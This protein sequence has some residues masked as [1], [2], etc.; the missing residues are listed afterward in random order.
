MVFT[1]PDNDSLYIALLGRDPNYDGRVF[2]GV[3][4]TG[5]FCRL[6][7]PARKPKQEN[8]TF[9]ESLAEPSRLQQ[10]A[11]G[12]SLEQPSHSTEPKLN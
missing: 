1:L 6:T 4:S 5:V 11:G 3:R 10:V 8:C 9:Y 7:C 2:V 12:I